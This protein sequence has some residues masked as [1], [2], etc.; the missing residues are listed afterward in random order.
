MRKIDADL[1]GRRSVRLLPQRNVNVVCV[2]V[3]VCNQHDGLN[4]KLE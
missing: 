3:C 2:C 1:E 4:G